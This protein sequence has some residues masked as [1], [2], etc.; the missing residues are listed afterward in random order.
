MERPS[1][2]P[3]LSIHSFSRLDDGHSCLKGDS[4]P[5]EKMLFE[6]KR[7]IN[8]WRN[9]QE[10]RQE[11]KFASAAW[12]DKDYSRFIEALETIINALSPSDKKKLEY[13][14]RHLNLTRNKF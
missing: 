4:S 11:K 14:R 5:Y 2:S 8:Q 1:K 6:K 13:A 9:E 7:K 10:L 12:K 3:R